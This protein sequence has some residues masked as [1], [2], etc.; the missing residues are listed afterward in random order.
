M[1]FLA[2][3]ARYRLALGIAL[4]FLAVPAWGQN[5]AAQRATLKGVNMWRS[6][7]K[8]WTLVPNGTA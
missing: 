6:W 8:R 2:F 1:R 4:P 3:L 7:S 5:G